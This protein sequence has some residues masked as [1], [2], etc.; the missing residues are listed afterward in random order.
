MSNNQRNYLTLSVKDKNLDKELNTKFRTSTSSTA[1][2]KK[3]FTSHNYSAI[4]FRGSRKS[5]NFEY[6]TCVMLDIDNGMT[7]QEA[8]STLDQHQLNRAIITSKSHTAVHHRFRIIIPL[9][10]KIYTHLN[11]KDV[12]RDLKVSLFPAVDPNAM[13]GARFFFYSPDTAYYSS[14]WDGKDYDPDQNKT[15]QIANA[16]GDHLQVT[17]GDNKDAYP[18]L[19]DEK[20]AIFCPFHED[21]NASAF[22][23]VSPNGGKFIHCSSCGK[24]FW[25]MIEPLSVRCKDYWSYST[26]YLE[27]GI[28]GEKFFM[29]KITKEKFTT[30]VNVYSQKEKEEANTYLLHN[31]HIKHIK[32]VEHLGD[33]RYDASS[34]SVDLDSAIVT[35][36]YAAIKPVITD[37][38]FIERYLEV[39]FKQYKDFIKQWMAVYCY[40][41]RKK[42]PYL[43]LKGE[44]GSGKSKFA[45]M[46]YK[47]FPSLSQMWEAT[48]GNFS[49]E[50]EKK[51]LIADET[52]GNAVSQYNMLKQYS[53]Q[54]F[55]TVNHKYIR[56]YEVPNNMNIIIMSNAEIPIYLARDEQPTSEQNN[57]FFVYNFTNFPGPI[58]PDIPKKLEDRIG[59]YIQTELKKVYDSLDLTGKRYS[60]DVPITPEEIGLYE[61]NITEEESDVEKLI[62]KV[63][64]YASEPKREFTQFLKLKRLPR[65]LIEDLKGHSTLSCDAFIKQMREQKYLEMD[66]GKKQMVNRKRVCIYRMTDKL[67]HQL[68]FYE[69]K[70]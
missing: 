36:K 13:D 6:A 55:V 51:L 61:S 32:R 23:K 41:N 46:L 8:E 22:V 15:N 17:T 66:K 50:A 65:Q 30:F 67:H 1:D 35:A 49:P 69:A 56:P 26:D 31:K 4:I 10:R 27:F 24:S 68:K 14:K 44:R 21:T 52:T 42:L 62:D 9:S 5:E 20:T 63:V 59:H 40:S 7:L 57:Q 48:K 60:I 29:E 54:E 19:L 70:A 18:S 39:M 58:D 34:Y 47:I 37:N 33:A 12:V 45:E 25:K 28:A 16:W 38:D 11:Y 43:I 53:G 2:L 3:V 64:D